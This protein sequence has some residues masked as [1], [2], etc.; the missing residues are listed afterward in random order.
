[1]NR[2]VCCA[3]ASAMS[4]SLAGAVQAAGEMKPQKEPTA[5]QAAARERM[6]KCSAEWKQAKTNGK[7]AQDVTWPKFWSDCNKRLKGE[8]KA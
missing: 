1:M 8:A 2:L 4:L 6:T 3:L 7:V 5:A